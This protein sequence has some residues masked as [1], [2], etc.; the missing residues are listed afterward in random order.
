MFFLIIF[1]GCEFM[2]FSVI[3]GDIRQVSLA[4]RLFRLGHNVTVFCVDREN[5]VEGVKTADSLNECLKNAKYVI[6]PLPLSADN[7]KINNTDITL[8]EFFSN[9]N[10]NM[11]VFGGKISNEAYQLSPYTI[12]DYYVKEELQIKN[13]VLTAEGAVMEAIKNTYKALKDCKVLITGYGRISRALSK[14]LRAFDCSITI[15]A[16]K[17]KD[18]A[19]IEAEGFTAVNT[20]KLSNLNEYDVIFNTVPAHIIPDELLDTIDKNAVIIELA[21]KPYGFDTELAEKNGVRFV[22]ASSLPGK[23]APISASDILC[24]TILNIISRRCSYGT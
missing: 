15:S 2:D 23:T 21:S 18:L 20:E 3:G 24:D 22:I 7:E 11:L 4:N 14:L 10:K 6:L 9:I 19:W 8:K 1:L 13:A 16:R 17:E 5:L 12:I